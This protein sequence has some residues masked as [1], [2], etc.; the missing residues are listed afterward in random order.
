MGRKGLQSGKMIRKADALDQ[1]RQAMGSGK[2]IGAFTWWALREVAVR[3]S[4]L[5]DEMSAAG[6][7]PEKYMPAE[8]KAHSAFRKAIDSFKSASGDALL[9]A[10]VPHRSQSD[11]IVWAVLDKSVDVAAERVTTV[12][13]AKVIFWKAAERVTTEGSH[14]LLPHIV[15]AY[16]ALLDTHVAEDIRHMLRTNLSESMGGISLRETGGIFFVAAPYFTELY[17]HRQVV[18]A[19]GSRL[20]VVPIHEGGD[21]GEE[22]R[23]TLEEELRLLDKDV[24]EFDGPRRSTLEERLAVFEGLRGKLEMY[25]AVLS[26]KS[27]DLRVKISALEAKVSAMID[28]AEEEPA[29]MEI[30]GAA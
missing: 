22:A 5:R 9:E 29:Q 8:I 18:G 23:G 16:E 7:D 19:I 15:A 11:R 24:A 26:F 6:L 3:R 12:Q 13:A 28:E 20:S 30:G 17:A 14:P 1:I 25:S 27:D 4:K 2:P 10:I 21:M